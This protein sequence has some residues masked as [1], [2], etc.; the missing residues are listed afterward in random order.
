M[1]QNL[2]RHF[3]WNGMKQDV[4]EFVKQCSMCQQV[5]AEHQSLILFVLDSQVICTKM[6]AYI[7]IKV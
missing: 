1:Y 7:Y 6:I 2:K 5:K 3:W 4:A